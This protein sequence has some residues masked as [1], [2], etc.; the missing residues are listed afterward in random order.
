MILGADW[1][2]MLSF[3]YLSYSLWTCLCNINVGFFV[4]LKNILISY[5]PIYAGNALCTVRYTGA[6]PCILTIRSTSFPVSQKSVDSKS[7]KASISQVDLS[8]FDE[9]LFFFFLCMDILFLG[10]LKRQVRKCLS[11]S[12]F[13]L[14]TIDP[15]SLLQ[16]SMDHLYQW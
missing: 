14:L 8:T 13:Y 11:I 10:S 4:W 2:S 12:L 16:R 1:C 3:L 9:G 7:D 5:R 15:N 6:S